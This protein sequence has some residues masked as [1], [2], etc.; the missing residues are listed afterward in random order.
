MPTI[1]DLVAE[2]IAAGRL[3]RIPDGTR[4]I[5]PRDRTGKDPNQRPESC[6]SGRQIHACPGA[7]DMRW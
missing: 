4:A 1:D 6:G 2:A 3:R 5:P 7:D